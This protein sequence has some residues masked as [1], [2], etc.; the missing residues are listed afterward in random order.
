MSLNSNNPVD[1]IYID[2]QKAF[3]SV[4]HTKLLHKHSAIGIPP[5]FISWTAAFHAHRSQHVYVEH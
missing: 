3:D 5:L 1:V 4:F 2:F